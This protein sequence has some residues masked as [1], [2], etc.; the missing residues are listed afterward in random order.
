M[1]LLSLVVF[2]IFPFAALPQC[3]TTPAA[4]GGST[5]VGPLTVTGVAGAPTSMD[6]MIGSGV[7][8]ASL[9][10]HIKLSGATG[11]LMESDNGGP[12]HS[13]VGATGPQG[14]AGPQ[15]PVGATGPQGPAGASGGLVVISLKPGVT[16]T[17]TFVTTT[18]IS[19]S[20][21]DTYI[22]AMTCQ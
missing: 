15:G 18:R 17:C 12:F 13:L 6:F 16:Y 21:S 5:C 19:K 9:V 7:D 8:L 11:Q 10:G 1:R 22:G 14:P 20:N 3:S 4:G 2:L